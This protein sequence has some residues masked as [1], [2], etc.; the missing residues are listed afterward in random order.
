MK[1]LFDKHVLPV[2]GQYSPRKITLTPLQLLVSFHVERDRLNRIAYCIFDRHEVPRALHW[3]SGA[4][5]DSEV[6]A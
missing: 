5:S 3:V 2:L 1:Y 6:E 4:A